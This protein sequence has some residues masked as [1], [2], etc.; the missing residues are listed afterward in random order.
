MDTDTKDTIEKFV[1]M[2]FL[3]KRKIQNLYEVSFLEEGIV[4][5][6]GVME[7]VAFIEDTYGFKV[8]DEEIVPENLDS[9][10]KLVDYIGLK[11]K[12]KG[13]TG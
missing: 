9:V 6:V 13:L 1:K 2:N 11:V 10:K 4:D 8:E 5:S 3:K 7:L 12:G